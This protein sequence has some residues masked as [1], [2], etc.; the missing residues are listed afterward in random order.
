[1][2]LPEWGRAA[3]AALEQQ[4]GVAIEYEEY[5]GLGHELCEKEMSRVRAYIVDKL[6]TE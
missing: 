5:R 4:G 3:S 1:M 6:G 2:I